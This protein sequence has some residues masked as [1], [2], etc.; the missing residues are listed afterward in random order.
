MRWTPVFGASPV[1]L[2]WSL[3]YVLVCIFTFGLQW[4]QLVEDLLPLATFF[5]VANWCWLALVS[6][7]LFAAWRARAE[8]SRVRVALPAAALVLLVF[9]QVLAYKH[10]GLGQ[11]ID[12]ADKSFDDFI[13]Y[14]EPW[15]DEGQPARIRRASVNRL[16]TRGFIGGQWWHAK[17]SLCLCDPDTGTSYMVI[18]ARPGG[19]DAMFRQQRVLID[20]DV[21]REYWT[22]LRRKP[23]AVAETGYDPDWSPNG[24]RGR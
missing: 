12:D 10:R 17:G 24:P 1:V 16:G 19:D 18:R 20:E 2:A 5:I 3:G 21:R 23:A 11:W 4:H 22:H 8:T 9:V 6:V 13:A 15:R 14:I 7:E